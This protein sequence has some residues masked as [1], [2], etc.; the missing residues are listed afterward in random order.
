[1]KIWST[2]RIMRSLECQCAPP[3]PSARE[4][5]RSSPFNLRYH[6]PTLYNRDS[7]QSIS[8]QEAMRSEN[9]KSCDGL[10]GFQRLSS[11]PTRYSAGKMTSIRSLT[12]KRQAATRTHADEHHVTPRRRHEM[13]IVSAV[14]LEGNHIDN[15]QSGQ[16]AGTTP[17][18]PLAN[19][20]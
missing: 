7:L 10:K 19:F 14:H 4:L 12:A 9:H 18:S 5:Q 3:S 6:I 11:V 16:R 2:R 8:N 13:R 1:M 20:E 17:L 15:A